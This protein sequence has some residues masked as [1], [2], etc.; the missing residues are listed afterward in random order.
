MNET[1]IV[2]VVMAGLLTIIV[3]LGA[4]WHLW[5]TGTI[6][7][8]ALRSASHMVNGLLGWVADVFVY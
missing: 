3:G 2:A 4:L 8:H 6:V 5:D 7:S 1:P